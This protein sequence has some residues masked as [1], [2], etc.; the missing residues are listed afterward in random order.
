MAVDGIHYFVLSRS[1]LILF[2][3]GRAAVSRFP[4]GS[5]GYRRSVYRYSRPKT[6]SVSPFLSVCARINLPQDTGRPRPKRKREQLL[7]RRPNQTYRMLAYLSFVQAFKS[8]HGIAD[9]SRA[10]VVVSKVL[11]GT[12]VRPPGTRNRHTSLSDLHELEC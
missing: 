4:V 6:Q 9:G 12:A 5:R 11:D 7:G 3:L 10:G 8:K 1:G 2:G